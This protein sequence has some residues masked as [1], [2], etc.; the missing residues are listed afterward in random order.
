MIGIEYV[1]FGNNGRSTMA[2]AIATWKIL[3]RGLDMTASS[4]GCGLI[5][6]QTHLTSL[7]EKVQFLQQAYHNGIFSTHGH[8]LLSDAKTLHQF[9]IGAGVDI[10]EKCWTFMVD[11]EA[12]FRDQVL[13]EIGL[14]VAG[15]FQPTRPKEDVHILLGM[16]PENAGRVR[17][18]YAPSGF[19]PQIDSLTAY[20]GYPDT[21][22]TPFTHGIEEYRRFRTILQEVIPLSVDRA[23]RELL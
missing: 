2:E 11:L 17:E 15:C 13:D 23:A 12:R 21:L 4:S 10:V 9:G 3:D 22:P 18:I 16:T 7:P 20:V 19:T 8:D 14:R 5:T 1:C 6:P